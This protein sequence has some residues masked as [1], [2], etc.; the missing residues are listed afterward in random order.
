MSKRILVDGSLTALTGNWIC[1]FQ[2]KYESTIET[3]K[4][5]LGGEM[6]FLSSL[7][8]QCELLAGLR[9]VR[10]AINVCSYFIFSEEL[11]DLKGQIKLMEE[12]NT[13]YMETN[14]ELDEVLL[15]LMVVCFLKDYFIKWQNW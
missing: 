7:L 10:I 13:S 11:S 14:M 1:R 5:K 12:K 8:I 3:Y 15:L 9:L 4:K 2:T 6:L